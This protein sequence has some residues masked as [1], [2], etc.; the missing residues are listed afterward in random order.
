ML[1]MPKPLHLHSFLPSFLILKPAPYATPVSSLFSLLLLLFLLIK[2]R[3]DYLDCYH[4][5]QYI[6]VA[7]MVRNRLI[8]TVSYYLHCESTAFKSVVL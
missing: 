1:A 3:T 8:S 7:L 6:N 4:G 5:K 2:F